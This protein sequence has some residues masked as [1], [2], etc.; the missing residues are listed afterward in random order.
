MSYR[1]HSYCSLDIVPRTTY[2]HEL[3]TVFS[4]V[5]FCTV[6]CTNQLPGAAAGHTDLVTSCNFRPATRTSNSLLCASAKNGD[7]QRL[8]LTSSKRGWFVHSPQQ[9]GKGRVE[10]VALYSSNSRAMASNS[11]WK[12]A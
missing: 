10:A 6:V 12:A 2:L 3:S 4:C 9:W 5:L 1:T 11:D 7:A 8:M